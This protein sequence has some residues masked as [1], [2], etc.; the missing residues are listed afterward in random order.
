MWKQSLGALALVGSLHAQG[1]SSAAHLIVGPVR[2]DQPRTIDLRS[3][4]P[5]QLLLLFRTA[6]GGAHVPNQALWPALGVPVFAQPL[7]RQT[8]AQGRYR[9]QYPAVPWV[10]TPAGQTW[11]QALVRNA[12]GRFD[13]SAPICVRWQASAPMGAWLTENPQPPLPSHAATIGAHALLGV[14]VDQDADVDIFV[15][16]SSGV[17]LW[18]DQGPQGFVVAQLGAWNFSA[19][20]AACIAAADVDRD[21]DWDVVL[22]GTIHQGNAYPDVL[23][24]NN[25][26]GAFTAQAAFPA[27]DSLTSKLEFGDIDADGDPDLVVARGLDGHGSLSSPNQ[28]YR[29]QAGIF[30]PD[31]SF[32]SAAWNDGL[33]PTSAARFG[34]ADNDGDLDLFVA[35]SDV[36]GMHGQSGELN[37]LLLNNGVGDFAEPSAPAFSATYL[38]NTLDAQ[39][40]DIDLDGDLDLVCANN[41]A[42]ISPI[43]SG[44]L[45]I[46]QGG[47]QG[48]AL[49]TFVEDS[50]SWLENSDPMHRLRLA[51]R[52]LDVDTD[53]D[54]DLLVLVH[55]L[56]PSSKQ[57]L[58]LN[59]GGAQH[60][61]LGQFQRADAFDPGALICSDA[62]GLDRNHDGRMELLIASSGTLS[63]I[64]A[65][66]SRLLWI[67]AQ[68]P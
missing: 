43:A 58:L 9:A 67:E 19:H 41:H 61:V 32:A 51:I 50:G 14:D 57:L 53:G 21:G 12:D 30:V 39:W 7:V 31:S 46:N 52:A 10:A 24:L 6:S 29:N 54:L 62:I 20:P 56:F 22:G 33:A 38:D 37:L 40:V 68:L 15:L 23:Y 47:L 27:G 59:Q 49:A 18:L 64:P 8:D 36:S 34:D 16:H 63:G 66:A 45:W 65:L 5:Q 1:A 3:Q 35:R 26:Q 2:D 25:G 17:E 42:G 11:A 48:G 60:G 4:A 13:A 55:D 28:L 44:D